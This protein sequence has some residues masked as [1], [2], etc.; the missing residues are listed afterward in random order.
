M[1]SRPS[2]LVAQN[3]TAQLKI[4]EG[5]HIEDINFIS[6]ALR[7]PDSNRALKKIA[8]TKM[9]NQLLNDPT[10]ENNKYFIGVLNKIKEEWV[11]EEKKIFDDLR[12]KHEHILNIRKHGGQ[13][14]LEEKYVL[15]ENMSDDEK[16]LFLASYVTDVQNGLTQTD[17]KF[18]LQFPPKIFFFWIQKLPMNKRKKYL[19]IYKNFQ[20]SRDADQNVKALI[21]NLA[22]SSIE[23]N[24]EELSPYA[25]FIDHFRIPVEVSL[26]DENSSLKKNLNNFIDRVVSEKSVNESQ[27]NHVLS[28]IKSH[29]DLVNFL[30]TH[31]KFQRFYFASLSQFNFYDPYGF[32]GV[33]NE[34]FFENLLGDQNKLFSFYMALQKFDNIKLQKKAHYYLLNN[35]KPRDALKHYEWLKERDFLFVKYSLNAM[36]FSLLFQDEHHVASGS[37]LSSLMDEDAYAYYC[38]EENLL[39]LEVSP[40]RL[41]SFLDLCDILKL[42]YYSKNFQDYDEKLHALS[43]RKL[44]ETNEKYYTASENPFTN[45]VEGVLTPTEVDR[46]YDFASDPHNKNYE[47]RMKY[48]L[49]YLSN[50][51]S[52]KKIPEAKKLYENLKGKIKIY[53]HK[54]KDTLAKEKLDGFLS[55]MIQ[56]SLISVSDKS[57]AREVNSFEFAYNEYKKINESKPNLSSAKLFCDSIEFLKKDFKAFVDKGVDHALYAFR[58]TKNR[59]QQKIYLGCLIDSIA[60]YFPEEIPRIKRE[61]G[62]EQKNNFKNSCEALCKNAEFVA[63]RLLQKKTQA[64]IETNPVKMLLAMQTMSLMYLVEAKAS[65]PKLDQRVP[66]KE[67][68]LKALFTNK[69]ASNKKSV[70]PFDLS[71]WA[72]QMNEMLNSE[73][74]IAQNSMDLFLRQYLNFL[75]ANL[76]TESF[77]NSSLSDVDRKKIREHFENNNTALKNTLESYSKTSSVGSYMEAYHDYTALLSVDKS[78]LQRST[79]S[80]ESIFNKFFE[81]NKKFPTGDTGYGLEQGVTDQRSHQPRSATMAIALDKRVDFLSDLK[82]PIPTKK[83]RDQFLFENLDFYYL[84]LNLNSVHLKSMVDRTVTNIAPYYFYPNIAFSSMGLD[85]KE[86]RSAFQKK[87]LTMMDDSGSFLTSGYG[88]KKRNFYKDS[89]LL[90]DNALAGIS[91]L[92]AGACGNTKDLLDVDSNAFHESFQLESAVLKEPNSEANS[93]H[94]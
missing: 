20:L 12:R 15:R 92:H 78:S 51:G 84:H 37:S 56:D 11:G 9:F 23:N 65:C 24:E 67:E 36:F 31:E 73:G 75:F 41:S 55:S 6:Q 35:Q 47:L 80:G 66:K 50:K 18:Y 48:L 68:I 87:L 81:Y 25:H 8:L 94:R 43:L 46:F 72:N 77:E 1:I 53:I 29:P 28:F 86:D 44:L 83:I 32:N 38:Q 82:H 33:P 3:E 59:E 19:N 2:L 76:L 45:R 89:A 34:T 61:L 93:S 17:E 26:M 4:I 5:T 58:E 85:K 49:A 60:Y 70:A 14:L 52:I 91:L 22:A 7:G 63:D 13:V 57:V 62:G 54:D 21:T 88:D 42:N 16:Y 40:L 90:Y 30:K 39:E 27:F 10:H 79:E 69:D 64:S 71:N 74:A